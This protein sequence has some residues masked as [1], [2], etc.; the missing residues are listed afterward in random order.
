M[1]CTNRVAT[2]I[3][4]KHDIGALSP[5]ENWLMLIQFPVFSKMIFTV[6]NKMDRFN[7]TWICIMN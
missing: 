4:F 7:D 5:K 1:N 3:L 6:P 2:R